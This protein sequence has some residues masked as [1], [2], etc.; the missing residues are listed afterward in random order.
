MFDASSAH[1]IE[2]TEVG[3]L[4]KL[5]CQHLRQT[6]LQTLLVVQVATRIA[7]IPVVSESLDRSM[8]KPVMTV[9]WPKIRFDH[10][11]LLECL[12]DY[13]YEQ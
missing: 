8:R 7:M 2:N 10:E 12:N 4:G 5:Q 9:P 6:A 1:L 11:V 3:T 13:I